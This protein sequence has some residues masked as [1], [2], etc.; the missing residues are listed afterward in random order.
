MEVRVIA[1]EEVVALEVQGEGVS[2]SCSHCVGRMQVVRAD[3]CSNL[4]WK[5]FGH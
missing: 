1:V 3:A 5:V 4:H 2:C